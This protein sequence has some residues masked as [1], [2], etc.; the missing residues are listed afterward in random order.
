MI[1]TEFSEKKR[2]FETSLKGLLTVLINEIIRIGLLETEYSITTVNI[3][4]K[5][6]KDINGLLMLIEN[7]YSDVNFSLRDIAGH[8]HYNYSY[9][10][11]Y[12]K[13]C[14]GKGFLEFLNFVRISEAEK[15]IMY[16]D[17]SLTKIAYECGFSSLI[18]FSR[19]FKRVKGYPPTFIKKVKN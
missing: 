10:S 4:E 5:T 11:R 14:T 12:F 15:Q 8:A 17:R 6:K 2:G 3:K 19:T 18:S 16:S 1:I 9:C 7:N 13:K